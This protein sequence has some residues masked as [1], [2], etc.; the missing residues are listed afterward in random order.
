M[1]YSRLFLFVLVLTALIFMPMKSNATSEPTQIETISTEAT[2]P[3]EKN[4]FDNVPDAFFREA[5]NFR[6]ECYGDVVRGWYYNCECLAYEY[7]EARIKNPKVPKSSITLIISN[8]CVDASGAAGFQFDQCIN[9]RAPKDRSKESEEY[10]TCFANTFARLFEQSGAAP[11][12]SL[13][14][15]LQS[16]AMIACHDPSL[17]R[18]LYPDIAP[19]MDKAAKQ[20]RPEKSQAR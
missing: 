3:P 9:S 19:A 11:S 5:D 17:A 1:L 13:Y 16:Q 8:K 12:T 18:Q 2:S 7:L 10:C 15:Y 4:P 6:A 20:G 14:G